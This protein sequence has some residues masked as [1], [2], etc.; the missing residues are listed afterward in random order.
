MKRHRILLADDHA[1]VRDGL[2]LM[3]EKDFEVVGA[4]EDGRKLVTEAER[5]HPDVAL[6]DISMPLLNGIE[7]TRRLRRVSPDTK[8]VALTMH[9]DVTYATEIFDAGASGYVLKSA[10]SQEIKAAI[11]SALAGKR[12]IPNRMAHEVAPFL[13]SGPRQIKKRVSHLTP[14]QREVLQLLAEGRTGKQIAD[15]LCLSPRT[16]EF[17]KYSMMQQLGLHSTAE[18]TRYAMKHGLISS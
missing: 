8:V 12:Y 10:P 5:L 3:L 15:V 2:R 18:L 4:V 13:R 14:R 1:I 16:V 17:H 9:A 7:A 11:R 6:V